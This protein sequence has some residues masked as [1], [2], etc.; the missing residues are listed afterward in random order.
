M[1]DTHSTLCI[2]ALFQLKKLLEVKTVMKMETFENMSSKTD[3]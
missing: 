1:L 3:H 2:P